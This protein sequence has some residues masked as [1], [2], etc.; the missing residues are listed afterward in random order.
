MCCFAI[1]CNVDLESSNLNEEQRKL[2]Y[3][4]TKEGMQSI[5]S[6]VKAVAS[7]KKKANKQSERTE[8]SKNARNQASNQKER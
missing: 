1:C 4:L 3:T 8:A 5:S 6:E 7:K 2:G